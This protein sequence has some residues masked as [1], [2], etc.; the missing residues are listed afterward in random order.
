MQIQTL[1]CVV[2]QSVCVFTCRVQAFFAP[3]RDT[4]LYMA[5]CLLD[6]LTYWVGP[7]GM[8]CAPHTCCRQSHAFVEQHQ[9]GQVLELAEAEGDEG[10]KWAV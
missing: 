9:A 4:V 6:C 5:A 2:Q 1:P 7:A 10:G 3:L 8:D